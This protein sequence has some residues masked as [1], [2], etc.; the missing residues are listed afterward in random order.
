MPDTT[1]CCAHCGG[2]FEKGRSD[3]ECQAEADALWGGIDD[4][5]LVCDDCWQI[6]RPDQQPTNLEIRAMWEA[7]RTAWEA[8]TG[9]KLPPAKSS[10]QIINDAVEAVLQHD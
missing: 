9:R 1:Y 6:M 8:H 4:P 5:V 2:T 7:S 3:E 10:A